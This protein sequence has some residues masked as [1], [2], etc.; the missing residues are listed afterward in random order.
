MAL[1]EPR[2]A[3]EA[4]N[5]T[6]EH[7]RG[8]HW[9]RRGL[10]AAAAILIAVIAYRIVTT[11]RARRFVQAPQAVGVAHVGTGNMPEIIRALGTVTPTAAVTVVSQLSGYLTAVDF[12]E[13]EDVKKGQF[14]AQIDP[15][16]YEL[17][18]QQYRAALARDR[19]SLDMA[20]SD[21]ARYQRLQ[22]QKSIAEQTVSDQRY[23]V[24]QD[25]A[26]VKVDE[27]NIAS[28]N[29]DLTYCHITAPIAGR[30]GL[31]LIDPGNYVTAGSST[32]IVVITALKPISVIFAI[33]QNQ[34]TDVFDRFKTGA[35]LTV[36]AY[37]STDTAL[38]AAG[39]VTAIDN[40]MNT[41]TGTVQI[42]ALFTNDDDALFPNEFVNVVLQVNTIRGATLVPTQAVQAGAPGDYVYVVNPN[43]TVSLRVVKIG[44]SNGVDTVIE[45]G[46]KPGETVVT[47]GVDRLTNGA[48]VA[49]VSPTTSK[50]P[51]L[52]SGSRTTATEIARPR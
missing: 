52:G 18:L 9:G 36:K 43:H 26:V 32:G 2:P 27:A 31:R 29:L 8:S 24:E 17:Q 40:Q 45:S 22:A 42:R 51:K 12:R 7:S 23:V 47:D 37:N 15:R 50:N 44:I 5:K 10:I 21:L 19:A 48:R 28:A 11:H 20:R 49:V 14:L 30:V 4:S 3:T 25:Q 13:G 34:L 46:L 6:P 38:I 41:T 39:T 35:K 33:P 16:P 1:N